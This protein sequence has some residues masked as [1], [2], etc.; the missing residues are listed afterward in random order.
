MPIQIAK[1][2]E[3]P[4]TAPEEP[5][6]SFIDSQASGWGFFNEE[7]PPPIRVVTNGLFCPGTQNQKKTITVVP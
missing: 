5:T 1:T 2:P 4:I 6:N 3:A 7:V